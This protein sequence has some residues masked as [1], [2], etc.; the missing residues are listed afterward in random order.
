MV[1]RE[2]LTIWG[3]EVDN[4]PLRQADKAM[5]ITKK[6]ALA[7]GVALGGLAGMIGMVANAFSENEKTVIAFETMMGSAKEAHAMLDDLARFAAKTPFDLIGVQE[8]AKQLM[9]MGIENEKIIDTMKMLGDV[10]AGVNVPL[11]RIAINYGQIKS[12]GKAMTI[13]MK[14]FAMAGIPIY[15]ALSDITGKT[16]AQLMEMTTNGE[17]SFELVEQAFKKM[18]GEGGKFYDLM[19]KQSATLGGMWSNF[20]DN[21][22]QIKIKVGAFASKELKALLTRV[23]QFIDTNFDKIIEEIG[24]MVEWATRLFIVL[25]SALWSI[26]KFLWQLADA[27]GG[28]TTVLKV[29]LGVLTALT[30]LGFGATIFYYAK[31]MFMFAKA[32]ML[33]NKAVLLLYGKIF[34]IVAVIALIALAIEDLYRF[35][36]GEGSLFEDILG[37]LFDPET[38]ES[39][40]TIFRTIYD[41]I[42]SFLGGVAEGFAPVI[43]QFK[44]LWEEVS[45]AFSGWWSVF[46]E[47]IQYVLKDLGFEFKSGSKGMI[48]AIVTIAKWIGKFVG[49]VVGGWVMLFTS[50]WR[51]FAKLANFG[52]SVVKKI[53]FLSEIAGKFFGGSDNV[54]DPTDKN[55]GFMSDEAFDESLAIASG[56]KSMGLDKDVQ[57]VYTSSSN[58]S[59]SSSVNIDGGINVNVETGADPQKIADSVYGVI[60][61]EFKLANTDV[62]P[63]REN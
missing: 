5:Q 36:R 32:T 8:N 39:V 40:R 41:V 16:R 22:D 60:N 23:N 62:E 21:I 29:F 53:P 26:L 34:A 44:L 52:R 3:F 12:L 28:G 1:V 38:V 61:Q 48:D 59:S 46:R 55:A 49:S 37:S 42:A 24:K 11:S 43:E 51:L 47:M 57:K 7:L 35:A 18:T 10:S 31:G 19:F 2:L 54:V 6:S 17:I 45:E 58:N 56:R 33:A 9:A 30:T 27:I 25:G 13:D 63:Q 50:V 20:G 15:E 4:A 14:Q